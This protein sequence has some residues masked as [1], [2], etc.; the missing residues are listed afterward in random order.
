M[1]FHHL[2]QQI[3]ARVESHLQRSRSHCSH[4]TSTALPRWRKPCQASDMLRVR[5]Y[6]LR[7]KH[8][9]GQG[10]CCAFSTFLDF[11]FMLYHISVSLTDTRDPPWAP[12]GLY[13]LHS[14]NSLTSSLQPDASS[15]CPQLLLGLCLWLGHFPVTT[16]FS[17]AVP[18]IIS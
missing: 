1:L 5:T 8:R 7:Q 15:Q 12:P 10:S 2:E 16:F 17:K 3:Q 9:E 14:P 13:D 18:P 11:H 4:P 6:V